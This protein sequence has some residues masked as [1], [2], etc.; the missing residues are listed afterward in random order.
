VLGQ[1]RENGG[2]NGPE[3]RNGRFVFHRDYAGFHVVRRC[4]LAIDTGRRTVE[5]EII[6]LFNPSSRIQASYPVEGHW[7]FEV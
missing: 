2:E 3:E 7:L 6:R 5:V 4:I 1:E